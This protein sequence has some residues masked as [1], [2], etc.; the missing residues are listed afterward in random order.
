MYIHVYL[1]RTNPS[2][3]TV[4]HFVHCQIDIPMRFIL[5]KR[6]TATNLI[7]SKIKFLRM[8][9]WMNWVLIYPQ[10]G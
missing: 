7:S 4:S 6:E 3:A 10:R 5:Y 1:L 9:E 2:Q 8:R